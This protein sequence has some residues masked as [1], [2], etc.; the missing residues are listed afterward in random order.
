MV[1]L[2]RR[3]AER[4]RRASGVG[5][6]LGVDPLPVELFELDRRDVADRG[7]KTVVVKPA[8][9]LDDRQLGLGDR[10]P[11]SFGD[12]LGLEGVDETLG[13]GV[14]IG[15]PGRAQGAEDVVVVES[16]GELG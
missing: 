12:Q 9:P 5:R 14:V 15:V 13:E 4:A 8:D 10:A 1:L 3:P 11:G 2:K 7:V 16:L 6:R